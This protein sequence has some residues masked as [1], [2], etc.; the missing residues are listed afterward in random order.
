MSLLAVARGARRSLWIITMVD[1][2]AVM[3]TFFVMLFAAYGVKPDAWRTVAQSVVGHLNP[4]RAE[5]LRALWGREGSGTIEQRPGLDIGYLEGVLTAKLAAQAGDFSVAIERHG[6]AL[7]VSLSGGT[8]ASE[9][10]EPTPS[11]RLAGDVLAQSLAPIVNRVEIH[12]HSDPVVGTDGMPQS[13]ER[14]LVQARA[15][16][17]ALREAGYGRP[18]ATFG[19]G[20]SRLGDMPAGSTAAERRRLAQRI[21]IVVREVAADAPSR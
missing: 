5:A 3:V 21:D 9:E 7:V 15:G 14:S 18:V 13:W 2:M 6:D 4:G 1:L 16:A 12:G 19:H 8:L 11:L 10:G 20:E 17:M